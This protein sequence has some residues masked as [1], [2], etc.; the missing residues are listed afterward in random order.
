MSIFGKSKRGHAV[1][2]GTPLASIKKVAL[3]L[4]V[5]HGE[6]PVFAGHEPRLR[7]KVNAPIIN[8]AL[9]PLR[10]TPHSRLRPSGCVQ[11]FALAL[12]D[13]TRV[14]GCSGKDLPHHGGEVVNV[15]VWIV[16]VKG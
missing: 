3:S 4:T 12:T 13:H 6:N 5:I 8:K 14:I 9:R 10:F 7:A 16:G 1:A 15:F 11:W 2:E